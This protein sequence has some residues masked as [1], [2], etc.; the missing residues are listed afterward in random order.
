MILQPYT[1]AGVTLRLR[2][3]NYYDACFEIANIFSRAGN[4]MT[5]AGHIAAQPHLRIERELSKEIDAEFLSY[6]KKAAGL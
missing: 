4:M 1:G 5:A 2:I 6:L 3:K